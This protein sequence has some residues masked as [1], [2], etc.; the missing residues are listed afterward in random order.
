MKEISFR[1][2]DIKL[3]DSIESE[4]R[5]IKTEK[6]ISEQTLRSLTNII[7]SLSG[8]KENY[9]WRLYNSLKKG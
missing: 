3:F 1:D 6:E 7:S 2:D 9:Y 4:I 5:H 8:V